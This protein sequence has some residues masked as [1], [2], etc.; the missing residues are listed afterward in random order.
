MNA[1]E[2]LGLLLEKKGRGS[3]S[4]LADFLGVPRNYI[5]RWVKD[6][7]YN[8][9]YEYIN[10]ISK[11]FNVSPIYFLEDTDN[12]IY[13]TYYLPIIGKASCGVPT[14]HNLEDIVEMFP[15]PEML[16]R[17]G[18][19]IVIAEGDSMLPKI[20]NGDLVICDKEAYVDNG[21]IVHYTLNGDSGIK[22]IVIDENNKPIMLVPLNDK[23][24]PIPIKEIDELRVAKCIKVISDL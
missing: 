22:K 9:P 3:A 7:K 23:Y 16:Y 11:F 1:K 10:E 2:K 13:L 15:V 8:F 18:R 17:E 24:P 12:T 14:N 4:K 6:E 21:N 5:T 19:Y 20:K